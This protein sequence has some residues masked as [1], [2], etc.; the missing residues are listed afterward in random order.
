MDGKLVWLEPRVLYLTF[1]GTRTGHVKNCF[2][3]ARHGWLIRDL[4]CLVCMFISFLYLEHSVWSFG[5][6]ADHWKK[7]RRIGKKE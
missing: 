4:T 7:K 2:N 1:L 5:S 3:L 6:R